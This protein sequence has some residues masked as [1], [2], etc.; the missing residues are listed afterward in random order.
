MADKL[1]TITHL[2]YSQAQLLKT[3]LKDA[4]IEC[5]LKN[6]NLIQGAAATGVKVKVHE[7][8]V[9]QAWGIVDSLLGKKDP[10]DIKKD[11]AVISLVDFSKYAYRAA[12]AAFEIAERLK[13]KLTFYHVINQLDFLSVPYTEVV[14]LSAEYFENMK[15]REEIANK[16]FADFLQKL[17]EEI[18]TDRWD[19]VEKEHIIQV[20]YPEDDI[21]DYL[22]KNPPKI[23]VM[24][25]KGPEENESDIVGSTTAGVIYKSK[26]PVLVVPVNAKEINL[27]SMTKLVYT[28]NFDNKD[29]LSINKLLELAAPFDTQ[30]SCVHIGGEKTSKL[31]LAKLTALQNDLNEK[32]PDVNIACSI[33]EENDF[34]NALQKYIQENRVDL[35]SLTTHRRNVL[36]RLLNPSVA[37]KMVFHSNIPLLVFHS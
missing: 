14:A 20:G 32:Y 27:S 19:A 2:P 22:E 35:I 8:D 15:L 30:I 5:F 6:V 1:I 21:L 9:E 13:A 10:V 34:L 26:V 17:S 4:G 29:L 28:T 11:N 7:D 23:V 33:I 16:H 25:S 31:S 36:T 24:G 18:G 37:R 12:L 3:M